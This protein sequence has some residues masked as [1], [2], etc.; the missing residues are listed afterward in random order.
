MVKQSK[1]LQSLSRGDVIKVS[2]D[3]IIGHEQ[4]GYRPALV[5]SDAVFHRATGFA[6]CLPITSKKKGLLFEIEIQ[7]KHIVGVA[8]PHGAR[9]LDLQ[10]R[11]F[12]R[13]EKM[14]NDV[15]AKAQIVLSKIITG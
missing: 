8:L 2:F 7:G 12:T 1:K 15:I 13:V 11:N 6:L 10:N 9:M 4:A 5:I 14:S 3:P